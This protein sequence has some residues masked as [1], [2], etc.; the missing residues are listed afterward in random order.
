MRGL[1]KTPKHSQTFGIVTH[2]N[3]ITTVEEALEEDLC[4]F[5]L[6][7]LPIID[8]LHEISSVMGLINVAMPTPD[9]PVV[10]KTY[11]K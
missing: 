4:N 9:R 3:S 11:F 10:T 7:F 6:V 1:P 5:S 2:P 8:A